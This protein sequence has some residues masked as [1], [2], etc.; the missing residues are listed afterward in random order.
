[1]P[2]TIISD[3][4]C[5]IVLSNIDELEILQ[6]IYGGVTTTNYIASEFLL[7]LP[8]WFDIQDPTDLARQK[9][10]EEQVDRGEASA[11]ALALEITDSTLIVDDQRA[12]KLAESLGIEITGTIGVII[13]GKL[14]G[15]I[16]S[17]RPL[18]TKIQQTN[19]RLSDQLVTLALREAKEEG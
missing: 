17:I 12:R 10:L 6:K 5:L 2:R 9:Q 3:T 16:P 11:I 15:N 8:S 13:R 4:S 18:L 14:D 19:F 1:M 7:P